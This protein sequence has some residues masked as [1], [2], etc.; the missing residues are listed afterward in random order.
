MK[1]VHVSHSFYP[2]IGG[3]E[4]VVRSLA[5]EQAKLGHDVSVITSKLGSSHHSKEQEE[6]DGVEI[7]RLDSRTFHLPD[8]T[9]PKR[10]P[11]DLLTQADV[12]H[13]HSQ[14]SLFGIKILE[15]GHRSKVGTACH[16]MAVNAY[17]D[18]PNY[19]IRKMGPLYQRWAVNKCL[20]S[21]KL[22]FVRSLRDA[23]ILR[24][25]FDCNNTHYVPDGIDEEWIT[26]SN[27]AKRFEEEYG[28]S[29]IDF[30]LF[31]GRLNYLKGI[32]YVIR[33]IPNV[34]EE[35]PSTKFVFI[36]P[37]KQRP[38]LDLS[39]A[40]GVQESVRFT[41]FLDENMKLAA[42]DAASMLVVPSI[43]DIA[44]VFS[45]TITEAWARGKAVIGTCVGELPFRIESRRTG[46]LVPP[47]KSEAL[48]DAIISL[49][50]DKSLSRKIGENARP[51]VQS[52]KQ[53][54]KDLVSIYDGSH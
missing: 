20:R 53:I 51:Y 10:I 1:I 7:H 34:L 49:L 11:H 38:Y 43:A 50:R 52:W 23:E 48:A 33:S 12:I 45:M 28:L 35:W 32:E 37:G 17:G 21:S 40:L 42:V 8:L 24:R 4:N 31:I 54:A 27:N 26:K 16:F 41:G 14:N 2:A 30:V 25:D 13:I 9:M 5:R 3:I 47:R 22:R 15:E 19:I 18:H 29:G 6:I 44:E 46:L 39:R 36:G